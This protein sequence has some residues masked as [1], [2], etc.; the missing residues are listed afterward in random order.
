MY[1][2]HLEY[3]TSEQ[4]ALY[5]TAQKMNMAV[6]TKLLDAQFNTSNLQT[7]PVTNEKTSVSLQSK[8]VS[9]NKKT[10]IHQTMPATPLPGRKYANISLII[11][12]Q[13]H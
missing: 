12:F 4:N 9:P 13:Q 2:G 7:S 5:K 6:L 11:I 3:W 1:T 8:V 10:S